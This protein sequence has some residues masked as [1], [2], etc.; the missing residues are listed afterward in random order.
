MHSNLESMPHWF[1]SSFS[2]T[3]ILVLTS[4]AVTGEQ[5]MVP[6]L[7]PLVRPL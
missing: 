6:W 7:N 3:L 1:V 4:C 2:Q 5:T